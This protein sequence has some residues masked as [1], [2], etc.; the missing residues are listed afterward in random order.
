MNVGFSDGRNILGYNGHVCN[1]CLSWEIGEIHDDEKRLLK[2]SHRC[3]PQK[4]QKAQSVTDIPGIL[5]KR[6]QEL[7]FYLTLI[8]NDMTKQQELVGLTAV[9]VSASVFD[10]RYEEYIDLDSLESVTLDAQQTRHYL[11]HLQV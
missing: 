7:I 1:K 8:V 10:I 9:E 3:D 11:I 6:R 4:L 5:C 2:S